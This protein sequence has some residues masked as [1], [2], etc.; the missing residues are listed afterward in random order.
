M[1]HAKTVKENKEKILTLRV[2]ELQYKYLE[3]ISNILGVTISEYLRMSINS[4][5]YS[6]INN[7]NENK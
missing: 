5:M 4:G 1:A 7:Q 3:E 2:S 6:Y